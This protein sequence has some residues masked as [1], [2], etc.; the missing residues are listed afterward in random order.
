[1]PVDVVDMKNKGLSQIGVGKVLVKTGRRGRSAHKSSP[2]VQSKD[3][4]LF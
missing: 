1:M 3:L 2:E 4:Y